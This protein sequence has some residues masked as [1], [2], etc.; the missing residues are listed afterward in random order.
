MR[1]HRIVIGAAAAFGLAAFAPGFAE[2]ADAPAGFKRTG[3]STNCIS[4]MGR[5]AQATPLSETQILFR[6]GGRYYINDLIGRCA[7]LGLPFHHI[8][9]E[10]DATQLCRNDRLT[11]VENSTDIPAGFCR[12]GAFERIERVQEEE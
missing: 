4:A 12:L 11:I 9:L 1:S 6:E 5:T 10:R 2:A 8:R 7:N 3:E